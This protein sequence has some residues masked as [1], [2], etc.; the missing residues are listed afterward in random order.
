MTA[1]KRKVVEKELT[2]EEVLGIEQSYYDVP[3]G[4]KTIRLKDPGREGVRRA[5]SRFEEFVRNDIKDNDSVLSKT[6]EAASICLK[7]CLPFKMSEDQC[8][9]LLNLVGGEFSKLGH[10][11]I[12]LC[13]MSEM[14]NIEIFGEES[15]YKT[16]EEKKDEKDPEVKITQVKNPHPFSSAEKQDKV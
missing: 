5:R 9:K 3:V 11:A 12:R 13:G 14:F 16:E 10:V 1:K 8:F 6:L 15:P 2:A 4:N 7:E